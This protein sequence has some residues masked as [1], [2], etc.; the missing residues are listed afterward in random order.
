MWAGL[1]GGVDR[2]WEGQEEEEEESLARKELGCVDQE[3]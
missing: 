1:C 2:K 3:V